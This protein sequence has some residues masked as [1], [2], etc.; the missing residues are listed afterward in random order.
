MRIKVYFT[1]RD[2]TLI[3]LVQQFQMGRPIYA[4]H[5]HHFPH[6]SFFML[7]RRISTA[8]TYI[9]IMCPNRVLFVRDLL[10]F[11]ILLYRTEKSSHVEQNSKSN[12]NIHKK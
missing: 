2:L 8:Y 5:L 12:N 7:V 10:N 11:I 1:E 6:K 3:H 9:P 4:Y